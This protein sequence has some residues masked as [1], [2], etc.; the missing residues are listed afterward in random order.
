MTVNNTEQEAPKGGLTKERFLEGVRPIL[1][2]AL[3]QGVGVASIEVYSAEGALQSYFE[4]LKVG[5]PNVSHIE[6]TPNSLEVGE[7][8]PEKRDWDRFN[9]FL[10][11]LEEGEAPR[12]YL[13]QTNTPIREVD[14]AEWERVLAKAKVALRE[15]ES[16]GAEEIEADTVEDQSFVV[17]YERIMQEAQNGNFGRVSIFPSELFPDYEY[18]AAQIFGESNS[19]DIVLQSFSRKVD[20]SNSQEPD[21]RLLRVSN[22]SSNVSVVIRDLSPE[23]RWYEKGDRHFGTPLTSEE[24]RQVLDSA[25]GVLEGARRLVEAD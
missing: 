17:E 2:E 9:V 7:Y 19:Q 18:R 16:K 13:N 11:S 1:D 15:S 14:E 3:R 4:R 22:E 21:T 6:I 20:S 23:V 8:V 12:F 10:G 24:K 25:R 5:T